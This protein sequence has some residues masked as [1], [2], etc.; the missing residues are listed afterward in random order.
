MAGS[1]FNF[2][3]RA[4]EALPSPAPGKRSYHYDSKTPGL[5]LAVTSAGTKTFVVYRWIKGKGPERI[6][7]EH[8]PAMTVEQARREAAKV[9]GAIAAGKN[10]AED[11][12]IR[13]RESTFG[14]LFREY[15]EVHAKLHTKTWKEAEAN[16]RRYLDAWKE[17]RPSQL[18]ATDVQRWHAKLGKDRGP[19]AA[20][21]ALELLRA[22]INWAIKTKRI[23][24]M[25]LEGAE[26]PAT[27]VA[28]FKERA[29]SRFLQSDELPRFFQAVTEEPNETIRDYVLLSLLTGA[30]KTNVLQMRW[31][32]VNL[33]RATWH[34]PETK[35]GEAQTIPLTAE[36][37]AILQ[38]RQAKRV[39]D[40][41]LP[42]EGKSGHLREPKKGWRR[43]RERAGVDDVRIHDLRRTLGSWQAA[44][45]AS[46]AVIGKSLGHKDV[47]TTAIYARLDLDP[48][49]RAMET[50]TGAMLA[51][52]G[53]K[54][55]AQLKLAKKK[56]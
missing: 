46:L 11:R 54:P 41:V 48:V 33:D 3:K 36:A 8:F 24:R 43:I 16:F 52:A 35:N 6:T 14:T 28:S 45:G 4:L 1:K 31:A 29:R 37:V 25:M 50:A 53:L 22:V 49:R 42:G 12:R 2:T 51:A 21:R 34:I 9:N 20:N 7:L 39:N 19:Y 30:R 40:Y 38:A 56:A 26:N 47:S 10:P 23:D 44:T 55:P 18:H 17:K 27:G 13:R 5:G 15:L 32:D